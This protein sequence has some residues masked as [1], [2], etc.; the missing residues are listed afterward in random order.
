MYDVLCGNDSIN[1]LLCIKKFPFQILSGGECGDI[2]D[3]VFMFRCIRIKPFFSR[4]LVFILPQ[5]I[6]IHISQS[7]FSDLIN[8]HGQVS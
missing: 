5:F 7:D 4:P 8:K 6:L 2:N 1:I 3:I